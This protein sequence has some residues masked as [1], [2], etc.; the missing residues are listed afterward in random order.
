M[1]KI[2]KDIRLEKMYS[3]RN[4]KHF[5]KIY[6]YF[7]RGLIGKTH[8]T[9]HRPLYIIKWLTKTCTFYKIKHLDLLIT[10][11]G[12]EQLWADKLL[13]KKQV[14]GEMYT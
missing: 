8:R 12:M 6:L 4:V 14:K 2:Q 3:G 5:Q 13:I 10:V 1:S 9:L 7:K 11:T